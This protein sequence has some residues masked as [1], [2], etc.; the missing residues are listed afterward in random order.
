M[1]EYCSTISS[2]FSVEGDA[3]SLYAT[4]FINGANTIIKFPLTQVPDFNNIQNLTLSDLS[5]LYQVPSGNL[6]FH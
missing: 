4:G 3:Y 2:I 6:F 1:D 5:S